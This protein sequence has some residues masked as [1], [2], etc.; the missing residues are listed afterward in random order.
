[1]RLSQ[2]TMFQQEYS[3]LC[4]DLDN[5]AFD[6]SRL[7]A[8]AGIEKRNGD[9]PDSTSQTH[10]MFIDLAQNQNK[11]S[12]SVEHR[13]V[14]IN[15]PLRL[16]PPFDL[17]K[18]LAV[19]RRHGDEVM[20]LSGDQVWARTKDELRKSLV[21]AMP[22]MRPDDLLGIIAGY[23]WEPVCTLRVTVGQWVQEQR[24]PTFPFTM[25]PTVLSVGEY[26]SPPAWITVKSEN[27]RGCVTLSTI[28]ANVSQET[29][30]SLQREQYITKV[31]GVPRMTRP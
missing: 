27:C 17:V 16:E 9:G 18:L 14:A 30:R 31:L 2:P 19:D 25:D 11:L 28:N 3:Q 10:L 6:I 15:T 26:R 5:P 20:A 1:M 7:E 12:T 23:I 13:K 24:I 29:R 21:S 4:A 8:H 22:D